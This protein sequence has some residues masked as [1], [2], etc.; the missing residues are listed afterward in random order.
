[1]VDNIIAN[2]V[3]TQENYGQVMNTITTK[4]VLV[5]TW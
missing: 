3:H 5:E 4:D 1:M 2:H